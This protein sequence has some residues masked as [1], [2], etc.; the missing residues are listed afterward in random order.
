MSNGPDWTDVALGY[1]SI[2][3]CHGWFDGERYLHRLLR[4]CSTWQQGL[5]GG[6]SH[7]RHGREA[8]GN[9]MGIGEAG[10][11]RI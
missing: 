6:N 11:L 3:L 1:R 5:I 2:G 10:R 7:A 4:G 9:H 8:R